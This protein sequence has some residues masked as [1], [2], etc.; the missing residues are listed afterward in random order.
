MLQLSNAK[1]GTK[2]KKNSGREKSRARRRSR[3]KKRTYSNAFASVRPIPLER[4]TKRRRGCREDSS[5]KGG[6]THLELVLK[7]EG[8][9]TWTERV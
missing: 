6:Y 7:L 2:I 1:R 8:K 4:A 9:L 5:L 3:K